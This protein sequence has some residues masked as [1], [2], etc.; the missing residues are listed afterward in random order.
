MFPVPS[1]ATHDL[2]QQHQYERIHGQVPYVYMAGIFNV[3]VVMYILRINAVPAVHFILP[4]ILIVFCSI[5]MCNL[6]FN[7]KQVTT[8]DVKSKLNS[9]TIIASGLTALA[10]AGC[11][12][13]YYDR[14]V[15]N[16]IFI[17]ISLALGAFCIAHC[18]APLRTAP[19]LVLC[20]GTFP[21]SLALLL[22]GDIISIASAVSI[23]S[24]ACLQIRVINEQYIQ[25]ITS[26][27]LE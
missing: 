12:L 4:I 15:A 7:K 19:I 13:A 8:L 16:P 27:T 26:L 10:S 25:M 5:R 11:L 9:T 17:P 21:V 14:V 23:F 24:A 18:L 1:E 20:I 22:S 6:L 2:L 3:F